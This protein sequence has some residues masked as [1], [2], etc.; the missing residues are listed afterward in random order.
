MVISAVNEKG[1]IKQKFSFPVCLLWRSLSNPNRNQPVSLTFCSLQCEPRLWS[2]LE[3]WPNLTPTLRYLFKKKKSKK[4]V[5]NINM[6]INWKKPIEKCEN[7]SIYKLN[8]VGL[9]L[10]KLAKKKGVRVFKRLTHFT[11]KSS[12]LGLNSPDINSLKINQKKY[13]QYN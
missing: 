3:R 13:L 11:Q 12:W 10:F 7:S 5:H 1:C 2:W 9:F 8:T 4:S 6:P